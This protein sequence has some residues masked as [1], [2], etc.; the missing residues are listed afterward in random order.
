MIRK[1]NQSREALLAAISDRVPAYQDATDEVDEAVARVLGVNRTDLRCLSLLWQA[2]AMTAGDLA[3]A[4]GLTRGAVTTVLDRIEE[5]GCARRV[6]DQA[7]RRS[8]RIEI[9]DAARRR[10]AD[11]YGP[12]A[13]EG[14]Q[15]LEDFSAQELAAI[16]RFLEG[17][18]TL[19]RSHAERIRQLSTEKQSA[20]RAATRGA[21][22]RAPRQQG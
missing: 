9:T 21:K 3:T 7:D 2:G 18:W 13:R 14:T 16:L 22:R 12:L 4:A 19:Q 17:G 5:A 8:V 15:S 20:P 11:L 1:S 6:W 10:I